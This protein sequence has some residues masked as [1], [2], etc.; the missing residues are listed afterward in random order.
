M[1]TDGATES[2]LNATRLTADSTQPATS[3][4]WNCTKWLPVEKP[5]SGPVYVCHA[6]SPSSRYEMW[7]IPEPAA[8][9]SPA[10]V[11]VGEANQPFR[12]GGAIDAV[13]VGPVV[14]IL[15]V[16]EPGASTFVALS[17]ER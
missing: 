5:L 1:F 3:V 11:T 17:V 15:T 6:T 4:A 16:S 10:S 8:P 9:S 7:S 13:E 12:I 2:A 14:S